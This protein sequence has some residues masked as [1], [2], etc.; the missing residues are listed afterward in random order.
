MASAREPEFGH[1]SFNSFARRVGTDPRSV[2]GWVGRGL[3][4][5]AQGH[6]VV[7]AGLKWVDENVSKTHREARAKSLGRVPALVPGLKR[8]FGA[9]PLPPQ[10]QPTKVEMPIVDQDDDDDEE[11]AE[12]GDG[13]G[14]NF[15]EVRRRHEILKAKKTELFIKQKSAGLVDLEAA[16]RQYQDRSAL[17]RDIWVNFAMRNAPVIAGELGIDPAAVFPLLDRLVRETLEQLAE[18]PFKMLFEQDKDAA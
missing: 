7:E 12:L 18:T 14:L 2:S 5:N 3:P 13:A 11:L 10:P 6:V 9:A 4:T 1:E 15:N 16:I 17:E 8:P